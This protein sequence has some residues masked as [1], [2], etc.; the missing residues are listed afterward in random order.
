MDVGEFKAAMASFASGITLVTTLDANAVPL[1]L[2]A[3]AFSSVCKEPPTCFICVAQSAEA[4]DAILSTRRFAVNVLPHDQQ[5]VSDLFAQSGADK[6]GGTPWQPGPKLGC[7][8]LPMA[9]ACLE[10]EV[11][12][13]HAVGDHTAVFGI[14]RSVTVREGTPLLYFRGGYV[15]LG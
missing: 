2:T 11:T 1:G 12:S 13:H 7:P 4:H 14:L 5:A 8:T 9:L 3:T 10:C 6:F 15:R